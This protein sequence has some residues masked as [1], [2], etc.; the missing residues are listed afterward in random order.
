MVA[1]D[2]TRTLP[3]WFYITIAVLI[4]HGAARLLWI[5][6]E[7]I[8]ITDNKTAHSELSIYVLSNLWIVAEYQSSLQ[9]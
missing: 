7:I 1:T 4:T 9:D 3:V 2:I 6:S 5:C 8:L